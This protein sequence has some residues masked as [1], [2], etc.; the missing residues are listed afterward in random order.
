MIILESASPEELQELNEF[1]PTNNLLIF[2]GRLSETGATKTL[3]D[4]EKMKLLAQDI[5]DF[6]E[7]R[8]RVC[9]PKI[10]LRILAILSDPHKVASMAEIM[11]QQKHDQK[12]RMLTNNQ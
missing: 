10:I 5:Q 7:Y 2:A 8:D 1:N 3:E 6:T 9:L 12:Y 11:E 4:P